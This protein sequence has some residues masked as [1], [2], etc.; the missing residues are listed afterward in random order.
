MSEFAFV[1]RSQETQTSDST[2]D[3]APPR[4]DSFSP[5]HYGKL[6]QPRP[7]RFSHPMT[8]PPMGNGYNA[9]GWEDR[10]RAKLGD[11]T[12]L[13]QDAPVAQETPPVGNALIQE[14]R[15]SQEQSGSSAESE[16]EGSTLGWLHA[17]L[18]VAGFIPVVGAVAD[19]AN[20]GLY[21]AKGDWT[22]AGL[23]GIAAIP[24]IGDAAGL[25]GKGGKL[26]GKLATKAGKGIAKR[27]K[28]AGELTKGLTGQGEIFSKGSRKAGDAVGEGL[29][30]GG[31]AL[32]DAGEFA[33]KAG[34]KFVKFGH[35]WN[36][37]KGTKAGKIGS[38]TFTTV[39][40]GPTGALVG[41]AADLGG[42][43]G[44]YV[45]KKLGGKIGKFG[46]K[47]GDKLGEATGAVIAGQGTKTGVEALVESQKD[48]GRLG[49]KEAAL[50]GGVEGIVK[51]KQERDGKSENKEAQPGED[52]TNPQEGVASNLA[53]EEG[54]P[55]ASP[56]TE[57]AG[58]A[59]VPAPPQ[60]GEAAETPAQGGEV[61]V[62][63]A[64]GGTGTAAAAATAAS[65]AGGGGSVDV[66]GAGAGEQ[67]EN[68]DEEAEAEAVRQRLAEAAPSGEADTGGGLSPGEK[69]AALASLAEATVPPAPVGGGGGGGVAIEAKPAPPVP[70]VSQSEPAAAIS[71]IGSLPAVQLKAALGGVKAAASNQVAKDRADFAAN[72]PQIEI[73][74]EGGDS[75]PPAS[76]AAAA[77]SEA[78]SAAPAAVTKVPEAASVPVRQPEPTPP[79]PPAPAIAGALPAVA[80]DEKGK[81]SEADARNIQ[82]SI[83]NL[84][85][86]D[87]N[88]PQLAAGT[89]PPLE[90][91]G[92]ADPQQTA[93]QKAELEK[94]AT[95][96]Q[97]LAQQD[98]AQPLGEGDIRASLPPQTL[99]ATLAAAAEG[100]G[101]ALAG[102]AAG[103]IATAENGAAISAI[104]KEEKGGEIDG[105]IASAQG[106]IAS[107][108]A[109]KD[110]AIAAERDKA[111]QQIEQFKQDN[112]ARQDEER[113]KATAELDTL[114]G[115]WAQEQESLVAE[116]RAETETLV[117]GGMQE[118]EAEKVSAEGTA[119]Q[120]LAKGEAEAEQERAKGEASAVQEKQKGQNESGGIFGWLSNKVQGFF[121]GVKNAIKGALD[122]ARQLMKA[123]IDRAKKLATAAIEK[124]RQAIVGIIK[125]VGDAIIAVGDALLAKFPQTRDKF[126]NFMR[127]KVQQAENAVN[128]VAGELNQQIQTAL[129]ALGQ[130]LETV[131]NAMET[132]M[133]AAVDAVGSTVD[134]AIQFAEGVVQAAGAFAAI[135]PDIAANPGQWV[136]NLVAGAQDGIYNHLKGAMESQTMAWF[137]GKVQSIIGVEPEVLQQLAQGG[138]GMAEIGKM[139]WNALKAA[140]PPALITLLIEKVVSLLVPVVGGVKVVIDSLMAAW[141][142]VGQILTAF[143]AFLNFLKAVKSGQSG[144]Q[145]ATVIAAAGVAVIDFLSNFL[146]QRLFRAA[147]KFAGR[148]KGI[149][150][151]I[152]KKFKRNKNKEKFDKDG[153]A[154]KNSPKDNK[155]KNKLDDD[156]EKEETLTEKKK[157]LDSALSVAVSSANRS[158]SD[159]GATKAEMTMVLQPI[160]LQ[161]KLK[162]LE[163]VK[164]GSRWGVYGK[165]N[166]GGTKSTKV[167]EKKKA[168]RQRAIDA[169]LKADQP[170]EPTNP[171]KA[172]HGHGHADHGYQ[173]TPSQQ[174]DRIRTGITPSGRKGQKVSKASS[175]HSPESEAEALGRAHKQLGTDLGSGSVPKYDSAGEPNRHKV[176]VATNRKDGFGYQEVKQKDPATGKVLK[177]SSGAIMTHT[178]P[179][180]ISKAVVI[181]EYVPST[182]KWEALTYYP[183]Q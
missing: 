105:A 148:L 124:G 130:G 73:G 175:F 77:A 152:A 35:K 168:Q 109:Q 6:Q 176:T 18:D 134:G 103:A 174:G 56:P 23:S 31:E 122:R 96:A 157:R 60:T 4:H 65:D 33:G 111:T 140:I 108:Q 129:D 151:G 45:G 170:L 71:S 76:E 66:G 139:A 63:E 112:A 88:P 14:E 136:S 30:R 126:R 53:G 94:T 159:E 46:E 67:S 87:P 137:N 138:I 123:A 149:A 179:K 97:R 38:D 5:V 118:V 133:V 75:A 102:D 42:K 2:R 62:P 13:S 180:P 54:N 58:D 41:K 146:F 160:K 135:V 10:I 26:A 113:S 8:V 158:F 147:R 86:R 127:E 83:A 79:P 104:A 68:V 95:E 15:D 80:G 21:A 16:E 156:D 116:A 52:A 22:N 81:L 37:V 84:P 78:A 183:K 12:L 164:Q 11:R 100:A 74:V 85:T 34:D 167:D 101:A 178:D 98:I 107:Q 93:A 177:D 40:K 182:D 57:Q 17:A 1:S 44:K 115:E 70:D 110:S 141:G 61:A 64:A 20:A 120:E 155:D 125:R 25:A 90:L 181:F 144:P 82:A 106:E 154:D 24:G 169:V 9:P 7:S 55:T 43:G 49:E 3:S 29:A 91:S 39:L 114:R 69:S 173:V 51:Q 99:T 166:P 28:T 36:E 19:I 143:D 150:K 132:G 145:F 128:Q 89:A 72:P 172:T 47:Y 27:S 119:Q 162:K 142:A 165:V 153:V 161:Y 117:S 131:L 50:L 32:A 121:E 48:A 171:K 59:A 163:A 92:N